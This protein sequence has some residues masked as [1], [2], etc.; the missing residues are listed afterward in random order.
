MRK[1]AADDMREDYLLRL[2]TASST[3]S[4]AACLAL[5][6]AWQSRAH[7]D[8]VSG[9]LSGATRAVVNG[10]QVRCRP[11]SCLCSS[12]KRIASVTAQRLSVETEPG[13]LVDY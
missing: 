12:N 1:S 7:S 2:C 3:K 4:S 9:Q 6:S 10:S 11:S 8:A 5:A 13:W